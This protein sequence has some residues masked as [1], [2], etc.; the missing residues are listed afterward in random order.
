MLPEIRDCGTDAAQ[1]D[2]LSLWMK[3]NLTF[4]Q[5][6]ISNAKIWMFA[7]LQLEEVDWLRARGARANGDR[8]RYPPVHL[9]KGTGKERKRGGEE[10]ASHV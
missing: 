10:R 1:L 8:M 6:L 4:G 5:I 9:S 2:A 3:N 7:L